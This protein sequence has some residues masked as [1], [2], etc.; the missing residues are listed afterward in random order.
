[1]NRHLI[2]SNYGIVYIILGG[3][4]L[5]SNLSKKEKVAKQV[6][7][8]ILGIFI[9]NTIRLGIKGPF[10]YYLAYPAMINNGGLGLPFTI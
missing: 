1:M 7:P 4:T 9:S 8:S 3:R 10:L 2:S 5:I 6:W